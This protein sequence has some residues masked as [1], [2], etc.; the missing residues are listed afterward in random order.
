M[1]PY[2]RGRNTNTK[3]TLLAAA[4]LALCLSARAASAQDQSARRNGGDIDGNV[5]IKSMYTT[6]DAKKCVEVPVPD[7]PSED[8][9]GDYG[10]QQCPG[11]AGFSLL[12]LYGDMRESVTVVAPGGKQYPQQYWEVVSAAFGSVDKRAEWVGTQKR[13]S[14]IFEPFALIVRYNASENASDVNK[15]T[16]YLAVSKID[17]DRDEICV[18]AKIRPGANQNEKAR[19]AAFNLRN[20]PCMASN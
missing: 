3:K 8:Q 19:E 20:G 2:I 11:I 7:V 17:M 18:V 13:G 9:S 4:A 1:P 14:K 12:T 16:A 5:R 6:L 15:T 10:M